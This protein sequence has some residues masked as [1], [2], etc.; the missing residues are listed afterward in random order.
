MNF[1]SRIWQSVVVAS[2]V[3]TPMVWAK[4]TIYMC[5]DSTMQD[6][7]E[8]AYPKQGMG[9][10]FGYF[11]NAGAVSVYN[12]GR[13]GTTSQTYYEGHW[14][15][16]FV[17]RGVTYP[18]VSGLVQRGDYVF[19]MFGANDNGYKTGEVNFKNSIGGMVTE[20]RAKGA[21]PVLLTPIR[22][23]NFISA[24]SIYDSYHDYPFYMRQ[25]ADSLNV[26]LI[27][28]DTLSRNYLISVGELYAHRFV[29]MFIEEGEYSTSGKQEDNQ[30]LQQ[31]GANDMAR[32]VTE[33]IRAHKNADVKA[34]ANYLAPTYQVN[35]KVSP[36]GSDM[37]T[38]RSSYYPQGMK[39]TLKTVPK[40]GRTFLG[41]YDGNGNKV[42]G[43]A[44]TQIQSDKMYS[45]VMGNKSTQ[46]TAMY[47]TSSTSMSGMSSSSQAS[48]SWSIKG[49][50]DAHTP[51]DGV[52][53]SQDNHEGYTGTGF[54]DF[55]NEKDSYAN[56]QMVFPRACRA[57]MAIRYSFSGKSDRVVNV[58]LDHD[59]YVTF[60]STGS[61]D[62]WDT[63]YVDIDLLSGENTLQF[64]SMTDDGGPNI[65]GFGFSVEGVQHK[66]PDGT[67]AF[68]DG[69][70]EPQGMAAGPDFGSEK[71]EIRGD[72]L[73]LTGAGKTLVRVY[74]MTGRLVA[75][76]QVEKVADIS[77]S[78]MV[79]TAGLYRILV[80]QGSAR[81]SAT[82]AKVK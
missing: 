33:Q 76:K 55:V 39:V 77:L 57:K 74:D 17:K 67:L 35:V 21:I 36:E 31:M 10:D 6:W 28:L 78:A 25:V 12:A 20:S 68:G 11:F 80:R 18:A 63:A 62:V 54:F 27:D 43:N 4:V 14:K 72:F 5:G 45:F 69:E 40:E 64:I 81:F 34:L 8:S 75:Q 38:T 15:V 16:D 41:W 50:F 53:F 46:Y 23:S 73:R 19:I 26:P 22:R 3:L 65:D 9:Q 52:G 58:Y 24:D 49:F 60:P 44:I 42:S 1:F 30:H 47:S 66:M 71:P 61:F 59:Y 51:D 2:M 7:Y 13:G 29:N 32:M 82:W 70:P 79:G 37:A 48:S 56:F